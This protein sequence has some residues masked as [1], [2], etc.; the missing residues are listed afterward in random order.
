M[1]VQKLSM[2]IYRYYTGLKDAA[3]PRGVFIMEIE[4]QES[5]WRIAPSSKP[6]F[7]IEKN[8]DN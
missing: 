4:E 8:K 7:L 5:T 3:Q 2:G 1:I 6:S